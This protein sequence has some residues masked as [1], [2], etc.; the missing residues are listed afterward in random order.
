MFCFEKLKNL[1]HYGYTVGLN[2]SH[3][4]NKIKVIHRPIKLYL[5]P[6]YQY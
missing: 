3:S 2:M 4:Q 5:V 6:A 1:D